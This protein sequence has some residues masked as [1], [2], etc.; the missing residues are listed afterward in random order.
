MEDNKIYRVEKNHVLEAFEAQPK[1]FSYQVETIAGPT[2]TTL[3]ELINNAAA[4]NERRFYQYDSTGDNCQRF[5]AD[6]VNKNNIIPPTVAAEEIIQ[7]QRADLLVQQLGALSFVPKLVTD[8]AGIGDILLHGEG[9][10]RRKNNRFTS[11]SNVQIDNYYKN[12]KNYI[13]CMSKDKLPT[14]LKNNQFAIINMADDALKEGTH[15]T[16]VKVVDKNCIYFDS[17][18]IVPPIDMETC[19]KNSKLPVYM[20]T[21]PLQHIDSA[22]CGYWCIYVIDHLNKGVKLNDILQPFS[23][24][25]KKND[26]IIKQYF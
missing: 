9:L 20:N 23:H 5:V 12:D 6:V 7:P 8:T 17:F 3:K 14:K 10:I 26:L 16:C 19:L 25:T 11:L 18:G 1:D 15:W 4:N 24:N 13:G 2:E 22:M 21:L